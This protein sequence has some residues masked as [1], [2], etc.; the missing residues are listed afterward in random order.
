MPWPP[1][2]QPVKV[3]DTKRQE[4]VTSR[5]CPSIW[6]NM[7]QA[8]FQLWIGKS[9]TTGRSVKPAQATTPV[10]ELMTRGRPDS[11]AEEKIPAFDQ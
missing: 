1:E 10:A 11:L 8:P 4:S 9:G 5:R 2:I 3:M 6:I 7:R